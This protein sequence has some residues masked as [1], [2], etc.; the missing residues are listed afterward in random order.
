MSYFT[1]KSSKIVSFN[2]P[3]AGSLQ[4]PYCLRRF[5]FGPSC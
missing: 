1:L 2:P 4:N 3:V 5:R